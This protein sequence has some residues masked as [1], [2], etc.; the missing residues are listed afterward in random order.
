M[1]QAGWPVLVPVEILKGETV[2]ESVIDLLSTV[3]VVLLGYHVLPEQTPP[4][5]ARIQFEEQ[6]RSKL[7][8]LADTFDET[9][10][11]PETRLVFTHDEEQTLDR[12]A[13]EAGCQAILIPNPA[14]NITRLLVPVRSEA[15]V[16]RISTFVAALIED[17]NISVTL[18]HVAES[19]DGSGGGETL[20]ETGKRT[21]T[22]QGIAVETISTDTATSDAPVEAITTAATEYDAVVMGA[23]EPSLRS[24]L[25]GESAEQVA[26]R[27]LGPV[28]VVRQAEEVESEPE[29]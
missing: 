27:S 24:L 6:A 15:D 1:S 10:D 20:L 9:G 5:Q 21:L 11:R 23:S 26:A 19:E 17:R 12:V 25:F 13:E 28:V 3:P 8:V 16:R 4:G 14:P 29:D 7:E 22:Q 18:F 2:P